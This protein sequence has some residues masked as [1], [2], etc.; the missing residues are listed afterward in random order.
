MILQFPDFDTLRL[1]L[2]SGMVPPAVSLEPAVAGEDDAGRPWIDSPA[3]LPRTIANQLAKLGVVSLKTYPSLGEDL[4]NWLQ[5]LPLERVERQ[6]ELGTHAPVLF[7]LLGAAQLPEVV[8]EML[9]LSVDRQ[10]FRWI[11]DDSG[12]GPVLL[13]VVGPPYYTLL[14][15]LDR[16]QVRQGSIR[17]YV[18][19]APR[20]WVEIGWTHPLV[21]TLAP[22]EGQMLLLRPPRDWVFLADAP[23]RDIYE[24]LDFKLPQSRLDWQAAELKKR[25]IVPLRLIESDRHD[26]EL[27]VLRE[28]AVDQLD[29]LVRDAKD[30]LLQRLI[31]AVGR[32]EGEI[33]IVLRVRPS[34]QALPQLVLKAEAYSKYL[35]LDNLFLPQGTKIHPI[36]RR[37]AIR[38]LL[39][40]DPAQINWLCPH[41]DRPG[42]FIPES[43]PDDAFRPLNEWVD[44]VLDHDRDALTSWVQEFRFDFEPFQCSED[45]AEPK[46]KDP[47]ERGR[48]KTGNDEDEAPPRTPRAAPPPKK[49]ESNFRIETDDFAEIEILPPTQLQE[50]LAALERQF[51]E[52]PARSMTQRDCRCGK[53]WRRA[54]PH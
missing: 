2:A 11:R 3:K 43:L 25:L 36:L 35:K 38:K 39:A 5:A 17:A 47:P 50:E 32:H 41:P 8:G 16:E 28:I 33:T 1:V 7:E 30:N 21:R 4:S 24:I 53:R 12:A 19:R 15:A 34:K 29:A 46:P 6:P 48:R 9:R 13:R 18:E 45:A 23:F 31:F 54:M 27:W 51:L 37:D 49:R 20:V 52:M 10:S 42:V 26:A 40:E 44:Y 14:R 22:K